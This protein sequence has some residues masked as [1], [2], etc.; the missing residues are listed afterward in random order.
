MSA[1]RIQPRIDADCTFL[2][3]CTLQHC[4]GQIVWDSDTCKH[5]R[6]GNIHCCHHVNFSSGRNV[7]IASYDYGSFCWHDSICGNNGMRS[8]CFVGTLDHCC[9]IIDCTDGHNTRT[10]FTLMQGGGETSVCTPRWSTLVTGRQSPPISTH[11]PSRALSSHAS[12]PWHRCALL[13]GNYRNLSI[14]CCLSHC[15]FGM[16][17]SL[18]HVIAPLSKLSIAGSL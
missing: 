5:T 1:H 12:T 2:H 4:L 16:G 8:C 15:L 10:H 17:L 7:S 6:C 13:L 9:S 11:W 14:L 3:V 18:E